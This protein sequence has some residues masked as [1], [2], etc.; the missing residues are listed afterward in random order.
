MAVVVVGATVAVSPPSTHTSYR[1]YCI[2]WVGIAT[3]TVDF[4]N[5]RVCRLDPKH[6]QNH[7]NASVSCERHFCF[8]G[9]RCLHNYRKEYLMEQLKR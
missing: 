7:G 5:I 8:Y 4:N 1:Y 3:G 6:T 2:L 9:T